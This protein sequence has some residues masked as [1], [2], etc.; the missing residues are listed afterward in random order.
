MLAQ[1]RSLRALVFFASLLTGF[2]TI[3]RPAWGLAIAPA[4]FGPVSG[5]VVLECS[6]SFVHS[7]LDGSV[8]FRWCF[9]GC[10]SERN[11]GEPR[12]REYPDNAYSAGLRS[13][14]HKSL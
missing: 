3:S 12:E 6:P 10:L 5:L 11:A 8:A 7:D 4:Q 2:G 13:A 9:V 1:S 14:L